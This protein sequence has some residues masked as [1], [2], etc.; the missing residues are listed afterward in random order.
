VLDKISQRGM[1]SLTPDERR[2]LDDISKR[3]KQEH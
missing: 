1:S 3:F 2:F